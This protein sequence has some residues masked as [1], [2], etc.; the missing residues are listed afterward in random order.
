MSELEFDT[1]CSESVFNA[2]HPYGSPRFRFQS[3][4]TVSSAYKKLMHQSEAADAL[5]L[6]SLNTLLTSSCKLFRREGY[7]E[8]ILMPAVIH[9]H[10]VIYLEHIESIKPRPISEPLSRGLNNWY[11]L[12]K[13]QWNE[14]DVSDRIEDGL[15]KAA[16]DYWLAARLILESQ[17]SIS[18]KVYVHSCSELLKDLKA[19]PLHTL[20][21]QP[22]ND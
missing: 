9:S 22:T 7:T 3:E 21:T 18:R 6:M 14:R 15:L 17:D 20:D 5:D 2:E 10:L 19:N 16:H 12:W 13:K 8:S 11:Q 1:P 4:D